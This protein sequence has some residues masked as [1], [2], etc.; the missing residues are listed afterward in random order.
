MV[1]LAGL[2]CAPEGDGCSFLDSTTTLESR[3]HNC[4]LCKWVGMNRPTFTA[5]LFAKLLTG[6]TREEGRQK[7]CCRKISQVKNKYPVN[8][9]SASRLA[10]EDFS[11]S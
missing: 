5:S 2:T 9:T 6:E 11:L 1:P 4:R 7:N 3:N 10:C 8:S